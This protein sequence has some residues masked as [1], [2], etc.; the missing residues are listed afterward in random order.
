MKQSAQP[1][2]AYLAHSCSWE[3]SGYWDFWDF[4]QFSLTCAC[5]LLV[6]SIL[7]AE[8]TAGYKSFN[9]CLNRTCPCL[10]GAELRELSQYKD[11][12]STLPH[13]S[14]PGMGNVL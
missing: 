8:L 3:N 5:Y 13:C 10:S 1:D 7:L 14:Y 12:F 11:A 4:K 6:N 9:C 2:V